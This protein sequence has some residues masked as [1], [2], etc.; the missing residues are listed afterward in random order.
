MARM[1]VGQ[2]FCSETTPMP[3]PRLARLATL[4]GRGPYSDGPERAPTPWHTRHLAYHVVTGVTVAKELS[5]MSH[6][7]QGISPQPA[8]GQNG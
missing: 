7:V 1:N 3:T 5:I 8:L 6:G 2:T 4:I